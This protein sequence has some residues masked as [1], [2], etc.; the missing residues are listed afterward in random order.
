MDKRYKNMSRVLRKSVSDET[1]RG[2]PQTGFCTGIYGGWVKGSCKR[3]YVV[4]ITLLS[5]RTK[6]VFKII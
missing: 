5:A 4:M 2:G 1:S 3:I 6:S